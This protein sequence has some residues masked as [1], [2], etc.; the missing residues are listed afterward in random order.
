MSVKPVEE[1]NLAVKLTPEAEPLTQE[2]NEI[3]SQSK[4][5]VIANTEHYKEASNDLMR[6]KGVMKRIKELF[7]PIVEKANE[8]HKAACAA[9]K[10]LTDPLEKAEK[11]IKGAMRVYDDE[12]ERIAKVLEERLR[13]EAEA[14]AAAEKQNIIDQADIAL[15][16]GADDEAEE[17]LTQ[18]DAVQALTPLVNANTVSVS[19][20]AKKITWKARVVNQK[21]VPTYFGEIEIRTV[22]QAQLNKI[23]Q[24][25][26]GSAKIPGVE[27]YP[28]RNYAAKPL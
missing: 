27:F 1:G 5:L 8:A 11:S 20:I 26:S 9:R 3:V 17:L 6:I 10:S 14:K 12:Q 22:N 16:L 2:T 13:K 18:A 25:T 28:E 7:D 19:G 4:D 23:A 21:A 24:M 15:E